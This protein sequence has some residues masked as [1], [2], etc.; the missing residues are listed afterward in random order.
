MILRY[1][2]GTV[3]T[4]VAVDFLGFVAWIASGQTPVDGFYIGALTARVLGI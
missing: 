2:A 4:L 3:A 1:T